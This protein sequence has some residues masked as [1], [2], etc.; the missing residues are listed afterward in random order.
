MR[1]I[2]NNTMSKMMFILLIL[3]L[4]T[5][6]AVAQE[7]EVPVSAPVNP[8][9]L[10]YL[11]QKA[12]LMTQSR[13]AVETVH[14]FGY[15]PEPVDY[16]HLRGQQVVR[17][18]ERLAL[19]A[20]YDLR[21][22][23]KVTPVRDQGG[24]GA[25]WSFATMGSAESD[26]LPGETRDFSENNLKNTAGWLPGPCDGGNG[27]MS[28][29][30]LA[31][32][33]G[34]V[35]ESDD[36]YNAASG[37]SPGGLTVQKHYQDIP[38]IPG[39]GSATDN[40]NIKQALM[41]YGAVYTSYYHNDTYYS[42]GNHAYYYTGTSNT[43]HAVTIVG[44]DD[45]FDKNKFPTV[46]PGNGAFIIKNSWGPGWGESGYY[47]ISYY[48]AKLGTKE[49]YAFKQPE[50][51]TNYNRI[52]QYDPLGA[53]SYVGN[54]ATA[55]T[56]GANVFTAAASDNLAAVAFY[57]P[58]LNAAYEIYVYTNAASGPTS[59]VLAGSTSGTLTE[60]GYHTVALTTPIP[61]TS[62]QKF[63]IVL[64]LTTPGYNYPI[65][66]E[67]PI[68]NVLS[69]TA[70]AG[71]SFIS[72]AGTS[73]S[74]ITTLTG[75][76]NTNVCV[77]GFTAAAGGPDVT[78][79]TVSSTAP[80]NNDT[81]VPV[82][83]MVTA[84]FSKSMNG[85][86]LNG[87]TFYLNNGVT[88][89]VRYDDA[90]F[91]TTLTPSA[92]LAPNTLY[93]ATITTGVK[94]R[95]GNSMV[96][97]KTWSF[98]TIASN[99]TTNLFANPDF[100]NGNIAWSSSSCDS[101]TPRTCYTV[102]NQNIGLG[103]NGSNWYAMLGVQ[104][105]M[106]SVLYQDISIPANATTADARFWYR[107]SSLETGTTVYDTMSFV[108][109]DPA[110]GSITTELDKWSNV[111]TTGGSWVQ[112][113]TYDLLAYKGKT[114]RAGFRATT[115]PSSPTT[116]RIDDATLMVATAAAKQQLA[117]TFGGNGACS[118]NSIP[119]AIACTKAGGVCKADFD[120]GTTVTLTA[121]HDADSLFTSWSGACTNTSGNCLVI[122]DAPKA[123]TA[124][125]NFV[126]PVRIPGAV[127]TYYPTLQAAFDAATNNNTIQ[128]RVFELSENPVLNRNIAVFFKG[129]HDTSFSAVT[130]TTTVKGSLTI[131]IGS[132]T[133]DNLTIR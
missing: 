17:P 70:N 106:T 2:R 42:P 79:P 15:I 62:G 92:N 116:F 102:I 125:C 108:I 132:A 84:T 109:A 105:N 77:K 86:T 60:A 19:P 107:I 119:S 18:M 91:T 110:T 55:T 46:P 127:P 130:G 63:S 21:T 50:A 8:A 80:A 120:N 114:I 65:A 52:Y 74:D 41:S 117:I 1:G 16:S 28:T 11:N 35:N 122:M 121:T 48:D 57:T 96:L 39:R 27:T 24:C 9:L 13:A 5:S 36:P 43:N 103:H 87:S 124:S 69:P 34:P 37:V 20:S 76:A 101:A 56:W 99:P 118:V 12:A 66:I 26:L 104:D 82:N 81:G 94:D 112:S 45:N 133:V 33:G 22:L 93:T 111:D 100:E 64:K 23:G 71:E 126:Q 97:N 51:T 128:A 78:P 25:C 47:Y 113:R 73:W 115:D 58:V 40:D 61:L 67:V 49:N 44:W 75:Y 4:L 72:I 90:T 32:W 68:A 3:F 88:G 59:G 53:S 30:Y 29:A 85:T 14:T 10:D 7:T 83:A 95:A 129:G 98:T 123:V 6:P 31:R 38:L 131:G 54:G 89:V